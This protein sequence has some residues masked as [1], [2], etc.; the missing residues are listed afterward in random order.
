MRSCLTGPHSPVALLTREKLPHIPSFTI[1]PSP[2]S[3]T[4]AVC[5]QLTAILGPHCFAKT[6]DDAASAATEFRSVVTKLTK[7]TLRCFHD[8]FNKEYALKLLGEQAKALAE[9]APKG[10]KFG[11]AEKYFAGQVTGEEYGEFLTT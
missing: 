1:Y 6:G 2:G 3:E 11:L 10:N 4:D 9:K 8:L 7:F 5:I